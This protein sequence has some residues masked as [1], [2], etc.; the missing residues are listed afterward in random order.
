MQILHVLE[1]GISYFAHIIPEN[2]FIEFWHVEQKE[3]VFLV[4]DSTV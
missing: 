4:A 1:S 3:P 2:D